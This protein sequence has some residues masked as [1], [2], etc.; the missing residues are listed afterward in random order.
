MISIIYPFKCKSYLEC[1]PNLPRSTSSTS[2]VAI[3]L[4]TPALLSL[5][6]Y[7]FIDYR[8][9][10]PLVSP[11]L[12]TAQSPLWSPFEPRFWYITLLDIDEIESGPNA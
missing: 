8:F 10:F 3:P 6:S 7:F 9:L 2:V 1:P 4:K 5:F 12:A 11:F